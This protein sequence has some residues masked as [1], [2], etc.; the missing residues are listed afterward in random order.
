MIRMYFT[1]ICMLCAVVFA[2]E[3]R[4]AVVVWLKETLPELI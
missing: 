1:F 3:L 4:Q 2:A